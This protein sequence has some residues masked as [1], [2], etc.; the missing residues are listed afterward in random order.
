MA[1]PV[2]REIEIIL[3]RRWASYVTLPL[4]LVSAEGDVLYYNDSAG[5]MLG[6]TYDESGSMTADELAEIYSTAREGG[7]PMP[8]HE[9]PLLR[10]LRTRQ[11]AYGRL[12]Y[13]ALDDRE[14]SV[15]ICAM[16][17]TG[18]AERFLGVLVA[19]WEVPA[20]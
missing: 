7:E 1:E 15:E 3:I 16:P 9:L 5:R 18:L 2:Q 8:A 19:F 4:F 10:A 6:R 20:S 11:P 13:R 14:W 17:V 12:R